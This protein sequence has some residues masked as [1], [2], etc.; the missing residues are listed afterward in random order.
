MNLH[1]T[2][3]ALL[4]AMVVAIV[5][6]NVAFGNGHSPLGQALTACVEQA[7]HEGIAVALDSRSQVIAE[8]SQRR[9]ATIE[10]KRILPGSLR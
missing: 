1:L 10:W 5:G 9:S 3:F 2:R 6:A 4:V 8:M 7:E